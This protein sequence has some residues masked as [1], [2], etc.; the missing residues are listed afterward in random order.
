VSVVVVGVVS[1]FLISVLFTLVIVIVIVIVVVIVVATFIVSPSPSSPPSGICWR[2]ACACASYNTDDLHRGR[3]VVII[4]ITNIIIT[5]IIIIIIAIIII[6]TAAASFVGGR[7]ATSPRRRGRR[8]RR[9]RVLHASTGTP[10]VVSVRLVTNCCVGLTTRGVRSFVR[11]FVRLFSD[12][13]LTKRSRSRVRLY[14]EQLNN[15]QNHET[16]PTTRVIDR[17]G[18]L[19]ATV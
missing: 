17:S 2:G 8:R 18:C 19:A 1:R 11:S 5:I 10:I 9:R 12:L 16:M 7:S 4:V 13:A 14:D 6:K 3:L 15:H